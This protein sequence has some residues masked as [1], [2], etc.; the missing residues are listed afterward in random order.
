M[1][2]GLLLVVCTV[3]CCLLYVQCSVACCMYS[4]PLFVVCAVLCG[5]VMANKIGRNILQKFINFTTYLS[6]FS[7]YKI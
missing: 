7:E 1:Y 2:S 4:V 3:F 5:L 6:V